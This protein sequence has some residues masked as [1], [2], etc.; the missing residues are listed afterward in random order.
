MRIRGGC[1]IRIGGGGNGSGVQKESVIGG[2]HGVTGCN[3]I[4]WLKVVVVANTSE[5]VSIQ[6][7]TGY[8]LVKLTLRADRWAV[9]ALLGNRY[10][11]CR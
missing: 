8:S 2:R 7:I 6:Y 4:S 9:V 1:C 10:V 3:P 11:A 5:L